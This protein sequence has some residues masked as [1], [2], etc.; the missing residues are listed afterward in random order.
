MN[1]LKLSRRSGSLALSKMAAPDDEFFA[2]L[3][4]NFAGIGCIMEAQTTV[5][6]S[7]QCGLFIGEYKKYTVS[8][9]TF[10][11]KDSFS[12]LFIVYVDLQ[13]SMDQLSC[14]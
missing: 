8:G 13:V 3:E 14:A 11:F 5:S 1:E 6:N 2:S 9:E 12:K 10:S 7:I 4:R